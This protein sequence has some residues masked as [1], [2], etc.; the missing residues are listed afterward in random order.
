M[1]KP[2][3]VPPAPVRWV[4][5]EDGFETAVVFEPG[6]NDRGGDYGVHGMDFRFLLRGPKGAAGFVMTTGWVPGERG[7]NPGV[8]GLFPM[9]MD[10]AY[11][12][13]SPQREGQERSAEKC[14]YLD[15][16][17]CFSEGAFMAAEPVL[18]AF[19]VRGDAAV[20]ETLREWHDNLHATITEA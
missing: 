8:A 13:H 1:S 7:V 6:Y 11:H 14:P 12:A 10:V 9:A 4:P 17:P 16:Q 15:G 19:I 3:R 5:L 2:D 18:A 20:W